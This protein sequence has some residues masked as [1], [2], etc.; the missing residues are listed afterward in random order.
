GRRADRGAGDVPRGDAG[1]EAVDS[2]L[3]HRLD[4][5]RAVRAVPAA[6]RGADPAV[7]AGGLAD[8]RRRAARRVRGDGAP[9][10]RRRMVHRHFRPAGHH[11]RRAVRGVPDDGPDHGGAVDRRGGDRLRHPADHR[12]RAVE[13][14][15]GLVKIFGP[16]LTPEGGGGERGKGR[17]EDAYS[18]T[19]LRWPRSPKTSCTTTKNSGM[20]NRPSGVPA[21]MPPSTPVP[22]ACCA[23]ERAPVA[24]ASGV[25]P[26]PK[27][28]EVMRIGRRR[29]RT[30]L[31]VAS[32]SPLPSSRYCLANST[33]RLAFFEVRPTVVSMATWKYTS[34]SMPRRPLA[35]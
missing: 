4:T 20:K 32:I 3:R 22:M 30:A 14:T 19:F 2:R 10:D 7:P 12:G 29:S 21:I 31:M 16:P 35:T 1:A 5:V 27:A 25:T 34:R 24:S 6:D 23:P 18:L 13:K 8:H 17:T 33:I 9:G 11:P 26:R 28:S 15:A